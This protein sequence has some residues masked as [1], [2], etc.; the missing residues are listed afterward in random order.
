MNEPYSVSYKRILDYLDAMELLAGDEHF[1]IPCLNHEKIQLVKQFREKIEVMTVSVRGLDN[2]AYTGTA[3][4]APVG[5]ERGLNSGENILVLSFT[6]MPEQPLEPLDE[7]LR[8]YHFL[9]V[10]SD[11]SRLVTKRI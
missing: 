10:S 7:K 9:H 11:I 8:A 6:F 3:L 2:R 4:R 5:R 1:I